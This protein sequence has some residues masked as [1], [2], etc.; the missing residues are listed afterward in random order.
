MEWV[1][2]IGAAVFY[3]LM[4]VGANSVIFRPKPRDW[5]DRAD[6]IAIIFLWPLLIP[7][8][9]GAALMRLFLW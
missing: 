2:W 9:L 5:T 6:G 4:G 7:L 1:C 8:S 3:L